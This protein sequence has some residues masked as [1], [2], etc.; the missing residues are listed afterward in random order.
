VRPDGTPVMNQEAGFR[1]IIEKSLAP[2]DLLLTGE[3][4]LEYMKKQIQNNA[5]LKKL[6]VESMPQQP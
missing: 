2:E 3:K 1:M 5:E 4:A 6:E